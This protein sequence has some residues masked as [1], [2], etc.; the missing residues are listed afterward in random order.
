MSKAS[1]ACNPPC[2]TRA[3]KRAAHSTP[4]EFERA[5]VRALGEVSYKE[6]RAAVD[7]YTEEYFAAPE[8]AGE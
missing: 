5:C 6:L 1:C 2:T 3:L 7:K 8:G 4:R